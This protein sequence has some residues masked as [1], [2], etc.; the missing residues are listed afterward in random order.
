MA[1]LL[2]EGQWG[3]WKPIDDCSKTCGGGSQHQWR[4]CKSP[5]PCQGQQ[6]HTVE[7]NKHDC[8]ED[9]APQC[10]CGVE[11][12]NSRIYGGKEVLVRLNIKRLGPKSNSG[13]HLS[14]HI[15]IILHLQR[16]ILGGSGSCDEGEGSRETAK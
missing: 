2:V 14:L 6:T 10:M 16:L 3:P 4:E 13:S 15:K 7:C 12:T 5:E 9:Q 1:I 8:P 11:K